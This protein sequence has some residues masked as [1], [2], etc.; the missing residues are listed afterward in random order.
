[1]NKLEAQYGWLASPQAF[2]GL[3]HEDDKMIVCDRAGVVF[4]FNFHT[5][6]SF[7]DFRVG[8]PQAGCYTPVLSSDLPRYGG[9]NRVQLSSEHFSEPNPWHNRPHSI[10]VRLSS[11]AIKKTGACRAR[12]TMSEVRG[13]NTDVLDLHATRQLPRC[14]AKICYRCMFPVARPLSLV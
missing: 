4:V 9:H 14:T 11:P 3:K 5:H 12:A 8:V 1:M 6:K 2:V 13:R 7:T 10:L